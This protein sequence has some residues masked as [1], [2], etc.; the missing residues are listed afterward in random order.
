VVTAD[1]Q[2]TVPDD[3]WSGRQHYRNLAWGYELE[4]ETAEP[5]P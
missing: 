5:N 2:P 4:I 1:Y 3:P